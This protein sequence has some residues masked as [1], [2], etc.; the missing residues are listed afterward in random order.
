MPFGVV[1]GVGRRMDVLDGVV[2]VEWE[3]AVLVVNLGRPIVTNGAFATRL[4][5]DYFEHLVP[6]H[7]APTP[8]PMRR[9]WTV[10]SAM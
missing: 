3:G 10:W 6:I 5:S 1:R 4:F 2:I 7:T 8:T 9:N